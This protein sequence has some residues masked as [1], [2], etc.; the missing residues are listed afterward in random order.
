MPRKARIDAPSALHHIIA[1]GIERRSIF[2]DDDDR[3]DFLKRLGFVLS[4]TKTACYAWALLPNHFHLLLRTGNVPISSVMRRVLTGY[5][6][7]YNC[8]HKRSGHLFQNR[9]KSIL[10]QEE[11]YLKELVRYIHLNPLRAKIVPD[12][13]ALSGYAYSGHSALMGKRQR[14]WQATEYVLGLFGNSA[15]S[16]RRSYA[17]FVQ[18]GRDQGRRQ[19][20]I[21]GGLVRSAGGWS[22]LKS[23]RQAGFRQKA[24]E[25]ILGDGDFVTDVLQTAQESLDRRYRLKS[26]GY[27]FERIVGRVGAVLGLAPHQVV[28]AGKS[29]QAV[30]ARDLVCYWASRE[31]GISQVSLARGFGVTQ[32]AVSAAIRRGEKIV[33]EKG[34]QL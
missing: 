13:K 24:D 21:G 19:D 28:T 1:R 12:L 17:L 9:F 4:E 18:K 31:L 8:R 5:A 27:D 11:L 14:P 34:L 32:P 7:S 22:A 6:I 16:S 10:C 26:Q 23:L 15:H 25:R 33:S 20:L 2:T 30:E 3:D 29:R